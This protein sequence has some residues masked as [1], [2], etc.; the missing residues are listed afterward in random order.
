MRSTRQKRLSNI[1][2]LANREHINFMGAVTWAFEFEGQ[3]YFEGFRTLGHERSRQTSLNSFRMFGLLGSERVKATS[4]GAMP[5]EEVVRDGV[6]GQP[7]ISVI[8]ARKAT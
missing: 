3:P 6:R 8:A 2:F 1:F 4:S 7:D 5:A